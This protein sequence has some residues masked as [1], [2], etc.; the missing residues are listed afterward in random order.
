[1]P[2]SGPPDT[3]YPASS[4]YVIAVGGTNLFTNADYTYDF[5]TGWEASGGGIS[6]FETAPFWQSYTGGGTTPIVPSAEAGWAQGGVCR[7]YRCA[8]VEPN[9]RSARRTSSWTARDAGRRNEL[10]FTA[11]DG[12]VG[13]N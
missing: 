11:G 2:L 1:M 5:E 6:Y 4:P 3:A 7:M 13:A 9:W 8:P 12:L 10:V